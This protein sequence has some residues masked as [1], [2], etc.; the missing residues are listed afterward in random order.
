MEIPIYQVDAFSDR[1]FAAN[2]AAVCPLER[3]LPAT[4]LQAIAAEYNLAETA[5]FVRGADG[6]DLRRFTPTVEM[7]LCGHATVASAFVVFRDLDPAADIVR[8]HTRSGMLEVR[9]GG[10]RLA[11]SLPRRA[12]APCEPPRRLLEALGRP[13]IEVLK[14][15]DYLA[16]YETEADV[17]AIR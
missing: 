7:D 6:Y 2:P 15:R 5:F 8:F 11:M 9:R 10:E 1:L 13:P 17:R 4:P 3:W 14:S 12:P 16:V